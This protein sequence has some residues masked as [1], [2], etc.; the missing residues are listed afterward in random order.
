MPTILHDNN[1]G[2]QAAQRTSREI[3]RN[4]ATALRVAGI[5]QRDAATRSGVPLTVWSRGLTGASPLLCTALFAPSQV[6]GT[7]SADILCTTEANAM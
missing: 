1:T 4:V 7:T 5:T 3:S 6:L 2:Q